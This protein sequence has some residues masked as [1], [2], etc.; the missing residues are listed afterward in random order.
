MKNDSTNLFQLGMI[1]LGTMGRNLLL[2]MADK[3]FKVT[4]YD[5][6]PAQTQLLEKESENRI[7]AFTDLKMMVSALQKPRVVMLLVPAGVVDVVIDEVS[8]LLDPEDLI[9]D[10]GNS[11]FTD[12]DR[13]AEQLKAKNLHFFG[14]GISGGEDG[15]RHGPSMMPGGDP[16]AY[17]NVRP[18]FEKIAAQVKG[19]PCVTYIGPGSSGHFVKMVHNGIEYALM[20]LIAESYEL[21]KKGLSLSNAEIHDTFAKWNRG[22]LKSYLLEITADIF[23]YK[24]PSGNGLLIDRIRDQAK[25]KGTGKWTSQFAM[26]LQVPIPAIDIAVALRDLSKYKDLRT[27]LAKNYKKVNHPLDSE[28]ITLLHELEKAF[29]FSL[30]VIYSQGMHLLYVASREYQYNLKLGSIAKIWR[31]GC[32]IRSDFLEIIYQAFERTQEL[33]HLFLDDKIKTLLEE[34]LTATQSIVVKSYQAGLP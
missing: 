22:K 25:A 34:N 20:Q 23:C 18:I 15:A 33:E 6:N 5:K 14:V 10:G 17:R 28:K 1:G 13:R 29:Y 3:G 31:G 7:N 32:I 24:D 21:M 2:N 26:D 9:I 19:E 16:D 8:D 4:G 30:I 27:K 11:K 12:T